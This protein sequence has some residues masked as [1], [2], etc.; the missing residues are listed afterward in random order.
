M[1]SSNIDKIVNRINTSANK[2]ITS[3]QVDYEIKTLTNNDNT[4]SQIN[5]T[6]SKEIG[7]G[8]FG[9][10]YQIDNKV[11]KINKQDN[12]DDDL[13]SE[14]VIMSLC[15]HPNV[16]EIIGLNTLTVNIDIYT[17]N[18]I[19]IE[20][21]RIGLIM[22]H[23]KNGS[24]ISKLE[25]EKENNKRNILSN[26]QKINILHGIC[27][28]MDYIHK[29]GFNHRDLAARNILLD[30]DYNAK[31]T[32]F[33]LSRVDGA[34]PNNNKGLKQPVA[35]IAIEKI[36]LGKKYTRAADVWSFGILMSET[37]NKGKTP[38]L[39]YSTNKTKI[40]QLLEIKNISEIRKAVPPPKNYIM[41][42]IFNSC[43]QIDPQKRP[44]FNK[45][46]NMFLTIIQ[47][48]KERSRKGKT[49]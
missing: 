46:K 26:K 34:T 11:V 16:A 32:D 33:G 35:W 9:L 1:N 12:K 49:T 39:N 48:L 19:K 37:F 38:Y 29:K 30:S 10:V 24:F 25:N 13:Y 47:I 40:K 31:I 36:I 42:K 45:L 20:G 5:N 2:K 8:N 18:N 22:N 4:I 17:K 41:E 28:G 27:T 3:D 44:D 21:T 6:N 14:A 15:K 7:H 23:Y 43:I